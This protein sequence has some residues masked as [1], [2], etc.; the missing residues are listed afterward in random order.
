MALGAYLKKWLVLVIV[1]IIKLASC[2]PI[3]ILKR[4]P[5]FLD[6]EL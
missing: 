5:C 6:F 3:L 1:I 4:V 2:L